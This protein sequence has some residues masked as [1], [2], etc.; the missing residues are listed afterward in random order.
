MLA[1]G[2]RTRISRVER[3]KCGAPPAAARD[4]PELFE[5]DA[6]SETQPENIPVGESQSFGLR[7][8]GIVIAIA[9]A[10]SFL[11]FVM[12]LLAIV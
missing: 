11:V 2:V 7:F 5:G 4:T 6:L 9:L 1:P 3:P 8:N 12:G 10:A